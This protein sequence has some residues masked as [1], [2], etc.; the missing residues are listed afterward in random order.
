MAETCPITKIE[1]DTV[2]E[3]LN[4][5]SLSDSGLSM[6]NNELSVPVF[7]KEFNSLV[8]VRVF[9]KVKNATLQAP[10]IQI[11]KET[12]FVMNTPPFFV[13]G[14]L[15][16]VTMSVESLAS[17]TKENIKI[18]QLPTIQDST[19]GDTFTIQVEDMKPYMEIDYEKLQLRVKVNEMPDRDV[20]QQKLK[21]ILADQ[22]GAT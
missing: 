12:D 13:G 1:I 7:R 15:H 19:L 18:I 10:L 14:N 20:K 11:V 2:K 4:G 3:A 16:S 21:I 6:N 8:Y 5:K 22:K 9:N 17:N